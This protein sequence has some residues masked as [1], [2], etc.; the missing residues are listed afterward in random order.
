M[1]TGTHLW[2]GGRIWT[3]SGAAEALLTEG[4]RIAAV[5]REPRVRSRAPSGTEIHHFD[6]FLLPGLVDAHLHL[7][8]LLARRLCLDLGL[9]EGGASLPE[10]LAE[11]DRRYPGRPVVAFG[12]IFREPIP[13][14]ARDDRRPWLILDRSGHAAWANRAALR[15]VGLDATRP[16]PPGGRLGRGSGGL[17]GHL[18]DGAVG[19][20]DPVR[21]AG[22][23]PG[24][25][26]LQSLL[27]ELA[28]AG[29]T[30]LGAMAVEPPEEAM[31]RAAVRGEP[32]FPQIRTF[33]R[34]VGGVP[35][36]PDPAPAGEERPGNGRAIGVKAFLDGAFGPRTAWL[37]APYADA[38]EELGL[39]T[40]PSELTP[41]WIAAIRA[42]GGWMALH[43]IG[44]RAVE[45]AERLG[46]SEEGRSAGFDRYRIEHASLTPPDLIER[47]GRTR[48]M[49]VVQPHFRVTDR[50]IE[51][52]LGAARARGAYAFASLRRSGA[53]LAGSSDAPYDTLDP[54][55][56]LG[57]AVGPGIAG[58]GRSE[59]L[60]V[61]EALEIYT[62]GGALSLGEPERGRLVEGARADLLWTSATRLE[63]ALA[64]GASAIRAVWSDGRPLAGSPDAND[65]Y[66]RG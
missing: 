24:A 17:T 52:R 32:R 21:T 66:F 65:E 36:W 49:L 57:A 28:G 19:L 62:R 37:R 15:S 53:R 47:L 13:P 59:S 8:D 60:G 58:E 14:I 29:L 54:W 45:A 22:P 11:Y 50:W 2:V 33:R 27:A 55:A 39:S 16:D 12:S 34:W 26:A 41:E 64:A 46:S 9:R 25:P 5:G 38:P 18:Y 3:G 35:P 20:L 10:R 51:E 1:E 6:G 7:G 4:D 30:L 31:I 61:E 42:S 40:A 56:G 23:S 48:R 44:D 43:A 63:A